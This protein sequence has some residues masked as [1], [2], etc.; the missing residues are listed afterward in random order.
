MDFIDNELQKVANMKI[1]LTIA[2]NL[3]K[4]LNNDEVT[5][6]F[7]SFVARIANNIT[8]E[9]YLDHVDK[10][11]SKLNVF[12]SCGS[13]WVIQSLQCVEVKTA[14]CLTLNGSSYI[15]S[16]HILKGL[17]KSLLNVRNKNE[18]FCFSYCIA[19]ALFVFTPWRLLS[20]IS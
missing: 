13:G 14:T 7:N 8:D 20:E 6:L 16:P 3:V 5:G 15:Q 4:P 17:S 12:A 1:G 18:N 10:L 2:V 11:I 19:A 9:E